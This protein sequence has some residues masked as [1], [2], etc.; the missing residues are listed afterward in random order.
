LA[1]IPSGTSGQPAP[2]QPELVPA[3]GPAPIQVGFASPV[4]QQRLTVFFRIILAIPHAVILYFLGIAA[5]VVAIIGWFAALFTGRLPRFAA[6]YL[7]GYLRW[8]TRYYAYILLLTDQYPPFSFQDASYP[9]RL[10]ARPGQLNRLAVLFRLIL[11]IPAYIVILLVGF[12]LELFSLFII[13][14]IVLFTG[15]MPVSAHQALAAVVRYAARFYG[16]MVLLTSEYPRG[17]FGDGPGAV[18]AAATGEAPDAVPPGSAE[19][20]IATP[21]P[22]AVPAE[23]EPSHAEFPTVAQQPADSWAGHGAAGRGVAVTSWALV[24]PDAAKRLMTLFLGL[25]V[26]GLGGYIALLTVLA[27]STSSFE[28][29]QNA[30]STV[31]AY[32]ATLGTT[33]APFESETTACESSQNP[34]GCITAL[35]RK[36]GRAFDTFASGVLATPMPAGSASTAAHQLAAAAEQAGNLFQRLGSATSIAQYRSIVS[37]SNIQQIVNQVDIDYQNLGTA[38]NAG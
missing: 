24:L 22:A 20:G 17:L 10:A 5:Y 1:E 27:S 14:L 11:G 33:L 26:V 36:V 23:A 37:S 18:G 35:D 30:T 31:A 21:P 25:G 38:L 3:T 13:W 2:A 4:P 6:D 16:Y 7:D 19:P 15:T 12:G 29:R 32:N 34:L 8:L 28:T 9:V